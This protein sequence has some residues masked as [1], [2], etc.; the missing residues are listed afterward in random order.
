MAYR[1]EF[2]R[3]SEALQALDSRLQHLAPRLLDLIVLQ[4]ELNERSISKEGFCEEVN[5]GHT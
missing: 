3:N 4:L 5:L 2:V 1:H